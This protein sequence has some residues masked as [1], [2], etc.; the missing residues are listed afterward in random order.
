[1]IEKTTITA[2]AFCATLECNLENDKMSD[3]DFREFCCNTIPSVKFA[4]PSR[5]KKAAAIKACHDAENYI[6]AGDPLPETTRR[7]VMGFGKPS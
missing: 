4:S 2:E 6:S 5:K 1:M 3:E 7:G